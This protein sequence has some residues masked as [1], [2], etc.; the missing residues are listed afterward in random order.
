MGANA[1]GQLVTIATQLAAVPL[2]L[3]FWSVE[4]YGTWLLLSAIPSYL[5]L[6]DVGVTSV[7]MNRMTMLSTRG[8][9]SKS[10]VVFQTALSITVYTTLALLVL[11]TLI[12]WL[13]DLKVLQ[14]GAAR[15][16]LTLLAL[17]ALL[18]VAMGLI[19]AVF[20]ASDEFALGTW[21]ISGA[22]MVEWLGG[23]LGLLI[24]GSMLSVA[25]GL[26]FARAATLVCCVVIA[27]RRFRN[28]HWGL[29]AVDVAEMRLMLPKSIAFLS[30]PL[31]NAILLQGSSILVG[32][33]FGPA[34]LA[35][36]NT[37]RTLSRVPLQ[38]LATVN[39]TL[40]P[41][42]SRLF[43]V[44][45]LQMLR[46]LRNKGTTLA[47]GLCVLAAAIMLVGTDPILEKWTGGRI[48]SD[49]ILLGAFL[50][51]SLASCLWQLDQ[52]LLSSTNSHTQLS[53]W[54]LLVAIGCLPLAAL[55]QYAGGLFTV[56]A[57]LMLFEV[58]MALVSRRMV[59]SS[60]GL[61]I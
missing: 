7:A 27:S 15:H 37:Y 55:S 24:A 33:L 49:R 36:F 22:R 3:H 2:F 58:V 41:E 11:S 39:R 31:G 16:T 26:F 45:N 17:V 25:A 40:W 23:V 8:E 48:H 35:L 18:N 9:Q 44:G 12:I 5:S 19:D 56:L 43:A 4:D 1:S 29:G 34:T 61:H 50:V 28:F 42:I 47:V 32:S 53:V 52:V 6:A 59:A 10:N 14:G 30:F 20:R 21:L 57:A 51:I 46:R 60:M 13:A 54:Y 38:L